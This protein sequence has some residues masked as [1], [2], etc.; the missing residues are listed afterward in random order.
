MNLSFAFVPAGTVAV[1]ETGKVYVDVGNAFCSGVLDHHHPD[2]PDACTAMLVLNHPEYVMGQVEDNHLTIIPH[3]YPDLDAITGAWFARQHVLGKPVWE[4]HQQWADYVC[5]VDRGF[6]TLDPA[7]PV[8]PY[9]VFMM[10]M[11]LLRKS[12][13]DDVQLASREMLKVGF[14]FLDKVMS[15]LEAG[16]DIENGVSLIEIG[17]FDAEVDAVDADLQAY[18]R[19]IQRAELFVASLPLKTGVG[20]GDVPGL[21]IEK[22]ESVMFKSWARGD[23]EKAHDSEGFVFLG[24]QVSDER[25]ILS[26]DPS[27]DVYLKGLGDELEKAEAAKR[28]ELGLERHG[29]NRPGYDSPDPWYDGRSPLHNYTI[30]DSPR[31]GTLLAAGE[32]RHLLNLMVQHKE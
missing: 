22:P 12:L 25:F 24:I 3:Q 17:G 18:R 29:E 11:H 8:T 31:K 28:K 16:N 1:S 27:S 4:I 9:S 23:T 15:W 14:D 21:W 10:R 5:M 13:P 26:V 20:K 6:T 19:D 7:K 30:V 2:S 32:V